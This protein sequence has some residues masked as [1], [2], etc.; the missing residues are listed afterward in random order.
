MASLL[1]QHLLQGHFQSRD[2]GMASLAPLVFSVLYHVYLVAPFGDVFAGL[3][4]GG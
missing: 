1:L 2:F 3:Q 4:G